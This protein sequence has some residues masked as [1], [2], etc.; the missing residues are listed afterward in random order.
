[1]RALILVFVAV[2]IIIGS[3]FYVARIGFSEHHEYSYKSLDYFLLT[4]SEMSTMTK[5]CEDKPRFISRLV[6]GPNS[7][8]I[9]T[10]NCTLAIDVILTHLKDI[11][12]QLEY[13]KYV[14]GDTS[15]EILTNDLDDKVVELTYLEFS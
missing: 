9:T 5:F 3:V 8:S 14:K 2:A 7:I 12:F 15:I 13:G 1:M 4:P 11:G 6:S 10:M